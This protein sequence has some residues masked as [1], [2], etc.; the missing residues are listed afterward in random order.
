MSITNVVYVKKKLQFE[1]IFSVSSFE[2][3][4]NKEVIITLHKDPNLLLDGTTV[5][6]VQKR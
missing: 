3:E 5:R 1:T 4:I 2:C 6:C